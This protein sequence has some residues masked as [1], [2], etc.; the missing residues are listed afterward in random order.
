MNE[1]ITM[2]KEHLKSIMM[3]TVFEMCAEDAQD[4]AAYVYA[5]DRLMQ[6]IEEEQDDV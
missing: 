6:L 2:S 4:V 3:D 5:F 1:V